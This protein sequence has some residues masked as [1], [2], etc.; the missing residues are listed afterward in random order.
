MAAPGTTPAAEHFI[1]ATPFTVAE[2]RVAESSAADLHA[3]EFTTVLGQSADHSKEIRERPADTLNRAARVAC[4]R[5]PSAA[6]A[7]VGRP[8]ASPRAEPPA[9]AAA[10]DFTVVAAMLVAVAASIRDV[11]LAG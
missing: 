10:V 9:S 7:T 5:A 2:S 8:E 11:T 6:T 1:T 4:V 3:A